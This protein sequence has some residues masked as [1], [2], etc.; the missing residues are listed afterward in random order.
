M[1]IPVRFRRIVEQECLTYRIYNNLQL[2]LFK[3]NIIVFS[4]CSVLLT[5]K[6]LFFY[7]EY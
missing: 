1:D 7:K 4:L 2:L 6:F 3:R 5:F